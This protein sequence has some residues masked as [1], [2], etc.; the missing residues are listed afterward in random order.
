MGKIH[1]RCVG[2]DNWGW[3]YFNSLEGTFGKNCWEILLK[4]FKRNGSNWRSCLKVDVN[5]YDHASAI[6]DKSVKNMSHRIKVHYNVISE[7][8]LPNFKKLWKIL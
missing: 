5:N 2:E 8:L 6:H 7:R 4:V 1:E 3:K